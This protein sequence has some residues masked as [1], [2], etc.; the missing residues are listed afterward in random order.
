MLNLGHT[1][2]HALETAAGYEGLARPRV[3]SA[4]LAAL[5]LSGRDVGQVEGDPAPEAGSPRPRPGVEAMRDKKNVGGELRLV[6]LGED[7]PHGTSPC[8][9]VRDRAPR[10]RRA[11]S[12]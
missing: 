12:R 2:A 3:A 5:R 8:P 4:S 7:G 9:R 11:D 1:F 10:A 6:L